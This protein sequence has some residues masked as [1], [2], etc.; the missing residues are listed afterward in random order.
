MLFPL[1][2]LLLLHGAARSLLA[3]PR[4][5]SVACEPGPTSLCL[6]DQRFKVEVQWKDFAG[7]TGAGQAVPVS[8]DTGYFWFFSNTNV[9]LTVK[10]LDGRT[11]NG[12]FWVF[13]AA[14]SNVEYTLTV[15][16]T[17]TGSAKTYLNPAGQFA[18]VGD[19]S[20]FAA[21]ASPGP[22]GAE[23][24]GAPSGGASYFV[25]LGGLSSSAASA[26][27][28]EPRSCLA[29]GEALC[30]NGGRFRVQASWRDF[31]G[32]TGRGKAVRLTGDTGYF[33]FFSDTNVELVIKV[34]D[35]R[36]LNEHFWIFYGAL[37]NVEYEIR[38]TDTLT[39]A[40]RMYFN[41]S[42]RFASAGDTSGFRSG[43]RVPASLDATHSAS[44]V[45]SS[46]GGGEITATAADGTRFVLR[47][48]DQAL[49]SE[50]EITLTPVTAM[51]ALP[52]TGGLLAA[53][54][55][56]PE[57]LPLLKPASLTVEPT[58]PVSTEGFLTVGV[59]SFA[60][61]SD[62][63]LHPSAV[64][65]SSV[66]LSLNR[67]GNVGLAKGTRGEIVEQLGRVPTTPEA[68]ADQELAAAAVGIELAGEAETFSSSTPTDAYSFLAKW[69]SKMFPPPNPYVP[70][71]RARNFLGWYRR[72]KE[73]M[74]EGRFGP[75]IERGTREV[76]DDLVNLVRIQYSICVDESDLSTIVEMFQLRAL[77][78]ALFSIDRIYPAEVEQLINNCARFELKFDSML[79]HVRAPGGNIFD[80]GAMRFRASVPLRW[81]EFG[82]G[83]FGVIV[84]N[85]F[86]GEGPAEYVSLEITAT[87]SH[88]RPEV[89]SFSATTFAARL[90][91]NL[92]PASTESAVRELYMDTG[93]TRSD[94]VWHCG[95]ISNWADFCYDF[96]IRHQ[97]LFGETAWRDEDLFNEDYSCVLGGLT[98]RNWRPGTGRTVAT[99][100]YVDNTPLG[101]SRYEEDT[102][103][104][105]IHTPEP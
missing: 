76:R 52:F 103:L 80:R 54:Q 105:L 47:V 63:R 92:T 60:D 64:Q 81:R 40:V 90:R 84:R 35:G 72:I 5:T 13:Y 58:G 6:N 8:A 89:R 78:D 43:Y 71:H 57:G 31:A 27:D 11:F 56:T 67:F 30:L 96:N 17:A 83:A 104:E 53:V 3:T 66:S 74:L 94:V 7:G 29:G 46:E 23:A 36:P 65:G 73:N 62:F 9:E 51:E 33:W 59:A 98:I 16:D 77:L 26:Q 19:T 61:G 38:V 97:N 12:H 14:L 10:V 20:A 99:K 42:G 100:S 68:E 93:K 86:P 55:I 70:M 82:N 32:G 48:P 44:G 49:L 2:A 4:S 41:P 87:P 1:C 69:Y 34:L 50:A 37:S 95:D 21:A 18:S 102:K 75:E 25:P 88:C 28:E 85:T 91:L 45:I 24:L 22:P 39:G 15:T 79:V 101:D